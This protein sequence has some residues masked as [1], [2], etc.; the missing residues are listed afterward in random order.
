MEITVVQVQLK[1]QL[2]RNKRQ[3]THRQYYGYLLQNINF[4]IK[5]KETYFNS[6]SNFYTH[7]HNTVVQNIFFSIFLFIIIIIITG[8]QIDS[9]LPDPF[10]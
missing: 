6:S 2:K 1:Q 3:R 9:M 10:Y 4:F 7:V 5:Q 8:T